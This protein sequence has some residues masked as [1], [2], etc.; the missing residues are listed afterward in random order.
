VGNVRVV[1]IKVQLSAGQLGTMAAA[2]RMPQYWEGFV[3]FQVPYQPCKR[4]TQHITLITHER[5]LMFE[6][7]LEGA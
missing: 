3:S 5:A 7:A 4:G 6:S 1:H 2:A